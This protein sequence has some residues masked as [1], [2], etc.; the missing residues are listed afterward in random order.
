MVNKKIDIANGFV[1]LKP[2]IDRKTMREYRAVNSVNA[3]TK[4][5]ID[6]ETGKQKV[7][8]DSGQLIEKA[9]LNPIQ[10]DLSFDVLVRGVVQ[11]ANVNDK[12]VELNDAFFENLGSDDF[13]AILDA[14]VSLMKT[15]EKE[16]KS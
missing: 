5:V 6:P 3:T 10:L 16:K 1:I 8:K 11:S 12:E 15:K 9:V 4:P 14:A 13:D 7:D 2:A